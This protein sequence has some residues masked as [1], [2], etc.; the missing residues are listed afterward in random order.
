MPYKGITAAFLVML[1]AIHCVS[2]DLSY[3]TGNSTHN[4]DTEIFYQHAPILLR[5]SWNYS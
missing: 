3:H 5:H 4:N 2:S 1:Q